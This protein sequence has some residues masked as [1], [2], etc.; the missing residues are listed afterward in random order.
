MTVPVI[1]GINWDNMAYRRV[2]QA[3]KHFR[4]IF[5]WG[6]LYK[7]SEV[8]K[9]ELDSRTHNSEPYRL[10]TQYY[11][12]YFLT[13]YL[14]YYTPYYTPCYAPYYNPTTPLLPYLLPYLI[15]PYYLPYY[16]PYYTP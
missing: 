9:R 10:L 15:H 2:Y 7:E 12:S 4:G 13:Y 8:P 14:T 16:A 3:D 5:E 1:D 6:F 11:I